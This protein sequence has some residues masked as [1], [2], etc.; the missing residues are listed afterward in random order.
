MSD[1]QVRKATGRSLAEWQEEL[2]AEGLAAAPQPEVMAY[3]TQRLRVPRVWAQ[4]IAREQHTAAAAIP[5]R[6]LRK[7]EPGVLEEVVDLP[8]GVTWGRMAEAGFCCHWLGTA[9]PF[10]LALGEEVELK[11]G[12][13]VA[14][15]AMDRPQVLRMSWQDPAWDEPGKV[16]LELEAD[17]P[18]AT[19]LIMR[20]DG[21]PDEEE[22]EYVRGRLKRKLTALVIGL[23][24]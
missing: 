4:I 23:D 2:A 11:D 7:S 3:L 8:A 17:G 21:A 20:L 14:V 10:V 16:S 6:E 9:R 19:R 22:A 12:T 15:R 5:A 13:R 1:A 24:R 18:R